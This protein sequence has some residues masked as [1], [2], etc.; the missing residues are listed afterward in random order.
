MQLPFLRNHSAAEDAAIIYSTIERYKASGI[1]FC[2]WFEY[3]LINRLLPCYNLE[4][5]LQKDWIQLS[6][7]RQP[8]G[9]QIEMYVF[10]GFLGAFFMR[11]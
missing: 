3:I 2:D 4:F 7:G 8:S 1:N 9:R 10:S 11:L 6:A 5:H